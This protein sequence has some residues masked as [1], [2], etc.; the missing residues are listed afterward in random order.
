[1]WR[2]DITIIDIGK[3]TSHNFELMLRAIDIDLLSK[4]WCEHGTKTT[5]HIAQHTAQPVAWQSQ[6][7]GPKDMNETK[8]LHPPSSYPFYSTSRQHQHHQ[9]LQLHHLVSEVIWCH[10]VVEPR[11]HQLQVCVDT[12]LHVRYISSMLSKWFV[13]SL[14]WVLVLVLFGVVWFWFWCCLV[15]VLVLF[16]VVWFWFW[17][18]LVC[19][20]WFCDLI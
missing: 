4:N 1:M 16:G 2:F 15:L 14:I 8:G 6:A 3:I 7:L 11:A 9:H 5:Q 18:C 20:F 19:C 17:C 13:S 12:W 10:H